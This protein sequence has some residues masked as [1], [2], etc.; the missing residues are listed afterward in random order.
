MRLRLS[1]P[2]SGAQQRGASAGMDQPAW[3]ELSPAWPDTQITTA[4]HRSSSSTC[5]SCASQRALP[6]PSAAEQMAK[7]CAS[8]NTS[9]FN[10]R[11]LA[12]PQRTMTQYQRQ[13][14][15]P[16]SML[17]RSSTPGGFHHATAA[18][19][20]IVSPCANAPRRNISPTVPAYRLS[21][22]VP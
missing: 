16:L 17:F 8:A 2:G 9:R 15:L 13:I 20:R 11:R 3:S 22:T 4:L 6:L 7:L 12:E 19:S 14:L 18:V 21:L 5:C 10:L 1:D